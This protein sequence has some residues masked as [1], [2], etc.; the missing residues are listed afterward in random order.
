MTNDLSRLN[1]RVIARVS[2]NSHSGS[3]H[4]AARCTDRTTILELDYSLAL[5]RILDERDSLAGIIIQFYI[6]D[7]RDA[8]AGAREARWRIKP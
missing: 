7:T 5:A 8:L 2:T 3:L 6:N 4:E 1:T